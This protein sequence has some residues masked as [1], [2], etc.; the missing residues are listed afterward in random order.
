MVAEPQEEWFS[1]RVGAWEQAERDE[2]DAR[3]DAVNSGSRYFGQATEANRRAWQDDIEAWLAVIDRA[4]AI[5]QEVMPLM[6]AQ[7]D[8]DQ[9]NSLNLLITAG[10][11]ETKYSVERK[12]AGS[13]L[14]K[15]RGMGETSN[16]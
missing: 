1:P 7:M 13:M 16:G 11:G 14:T 6:T 8:T 2:L 10:S 4:E 9:V 15:V 5:E 12:T 3:L